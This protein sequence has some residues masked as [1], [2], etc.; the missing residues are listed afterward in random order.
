[1][2]LATFEHAGSI[3]FGIVDGDEIRVVSR[4]PS[5]PRTLRKLLA[6]GPAGMQIVQDA[7]KRVSRLSLSSVRLLPPIPDPRKFMCVGGNY[8]S[9]LEE[10]ARHGISRGTGQVWFNKQVSC[11]AGPYDVVHRPRISERFDYEGELGIIIGRRCRNVPR[12]QAHL[13]IAGYVACNDLSV[14]DW[15]IRAPTGTLGKSFDTHG[16]FGPWLVTADEI[17]DPGALALRTLVNG[18]VRQSA[19]TREMLHDIGALLEE[20]TTAVTLEPGDVLAT[21]TPAGVGG[22]MRPPRFLVAGDVVRVEI[23]C[24]GHIENHVIEEPEPLGPLM[25]SVAPLVAC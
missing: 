21:G 16:P 2:K 22:L 6:A 25:P 9:H 18:E 23:E 10:A 11:V 24:I 14:R 8:Q 13:V 1:M 12:K 20:L 7:A 3:E 19:N 4:E 17:P 15:Q 5:C